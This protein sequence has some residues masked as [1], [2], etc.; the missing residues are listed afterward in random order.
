MTTQ[1]IDPAIARRVTLFCFLVALCEGI[2]L[3]AAGVAAGG[4]SRE[5][6]PT[7]AQKGLFFSAST[8]GLFVGA[9]F[10]GWL[11][12][13]IG[14][15][16]V[17]VGSIAVF[18]VF[19]LLT[20][21]AG[22]MDALTL[23]RL[24]TGLGLGG[25]LPNLIAFAAESSPLARRGGSIATMYIGMPFG[26]AIASLIILVVAVTHWR[27]VFVV[28]GAL[29]LAL[30]PLMALFLPESPAL[31]GRVRSAVNTHTADALRELFGV[32][33]VGR[34]LLLWLACFLALLTLYVMLSWLPT[35]LEGRGSSKTGRLRRRSGS[36]SAAQPRAADRQA[37]RHA[38]PAGPASSLRSRPSSS[39]CSAL[40]ACERSRSS[41][42]C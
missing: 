16:R 10:G 20:P 38:L 6:L 14:R 8:F 24:L 23:A 11:A 4:L 32:G 33:R 25:A 3:Q 35:L 15:K 13:R 9:V 26:G 18:G 22:S 21:L 31:A 19:S 36:T 42:S 29:P 39:R 40:Q 17:L 2:D 41:C 1:P 34:T 12:D 27:V 30:V 37:P 28:G 5:F 7:A